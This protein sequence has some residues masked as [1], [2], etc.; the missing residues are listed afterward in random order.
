MQ[1]NKIGIIT[2][3][4]VLNYGSVLQTFALFQKIKNLGY[5]CEVIDYQYPNEYH[6]S[7]NRNNTLLERGL[8]FLLRIIFFILYRGRKQKRRFREFMDK[9]L[10]LSKY[11][12]NQ[13]EIYNNPPQYDIYLTG[14]DQ[15]WNPKCMKGDPVF[16]C[17]FVHDGMKVSYASSFSL[18][19][20]SSE[21][22]NLYK[23]YLSDYSHIGIRE[24]SGIALVRSLINKEAKV[25]CDP[26]LLLTKREYSRLA[27]HSEIKIN[28]PYILV[29]A[30]SYAFNPY[31]ALNEVVDNISK[32]LQL[33][34]VYLH[35]NSIENYHIGHSITSAGP[36]E[37]VRLF[38]DASFIVTSSFHGTAFALNFENPFYAIIPNEK[39]E[40]SRIYSLLKQVGAED[41]AIISSQKIKTDLLVKMNYLSIIDKLNRYRDDSVAFLKKELSDEL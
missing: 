20:V 37:F 3:H 28:R 32:Q 23:K 4:R 36:N 5:Q 6:R 12:A 9:N 11:Y 25:V 16:F 34:V 7:S 19:C 1:K 15:V 35:V 8:F 14:S 24:S 13:E 39:T 26:T 38:M 31:P 40:D 30:L 41:R 17:D 21:Y 18:S 22:F 2:M 10:Q 27:E 33:Q 29:Y